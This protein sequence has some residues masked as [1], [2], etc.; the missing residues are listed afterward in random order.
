M[1]RES[2]TEMNN[3]NLKIEKMIEMMLSTKITS[4]DFKIYKKQLEKQLGML[5]KKS[6]NKGID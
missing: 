1:I 4:Q 3:L 5:F 6:S 2:L